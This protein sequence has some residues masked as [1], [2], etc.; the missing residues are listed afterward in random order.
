MDLV[1][2]CGVVFKEELFLESGDNFM[3]ELLDK[4]YLQGGD[5]SMKMSYNG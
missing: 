1:G 4:F 5:I 3:I 2:W